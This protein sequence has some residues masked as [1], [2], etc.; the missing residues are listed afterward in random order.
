MTIRNKYSLIG[1]TALL[2]CFAVIFF[3]RQYSHEGK[4]L[5]HAVPVQTAYG[6]GYNI[7]AD[8]KIFIKQEFMPGV[9]GK[10]GFKTSDDAL[11]VASLVIKKISSN[12]LPTITFRELDSLGLIKK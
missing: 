1:I 4:K 9:P 7:L 12:Q 2:I 3:N 5:L 11:L 8:E 6:W 10:Q